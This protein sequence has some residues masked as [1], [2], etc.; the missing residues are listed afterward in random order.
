METELS[1][2]G[3]QIADTEGKG[4]DSLLCVLPPRVGS[5]ALKCVCQSVWVTWLPADPRTVATKAWAFTADP[6]YFSTH[7]LS[8]S[9]PPPSQH[10]LGVE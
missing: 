5:A 2:P 3:S 6:L 7:S 10:N 9:S 8:L 4:R 1:S